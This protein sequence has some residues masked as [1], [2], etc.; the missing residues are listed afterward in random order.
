VSTLISSRNADFSAEANVLV[1]E[2]YQLH[3][4]A[5]GVA[6]QTPFHA[7]LGTCLATVTKTLGGTLCV[8]DANDPSTNAKGN[9]AGTNQTSAAY[10]TANW[11]V[12]TGASGSQYIDGTT[13]D[14]DTLAVAFGAAS[15]LVAGNRTTYS[16]DAGY[17]WL[18]TGR[19]PPPLPTMTALARLPVGAGPLRP[20]WPTRV[21]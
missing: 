13:A 21:L 14:T 16:S 6:A 10:K 9:V 15:A 18:S 4:D 17:A 3:N 12:H 2:F 19:P 8:I 5:A 11:W 1:D 7:V 20:P